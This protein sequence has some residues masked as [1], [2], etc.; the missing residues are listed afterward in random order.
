MDSDSR[1]KTR[2]GFGFDITDSDV[3]R[4]HLP[5]AADL[6][7]KTIKPASGSFTDNMTLT[8]KVGLLPLSN[9]TWSKWSAQVRSWNRGI[10]VLYIIHWSCSKSTNTFWEFLKL[11]KFLLFFSLAT[12]VFPVC[13]RSVYKYKKEWKC[14]SIRLIAPIT[15]RSYLY[16]LFVLAADWIS[17]LWV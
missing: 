10:C 11:V 16:G 1:K 17:S 3:I 2:H 4:N 12:W 5:W 7:S 15:V 14:Q 13:G 6:Q 9:K 8:C